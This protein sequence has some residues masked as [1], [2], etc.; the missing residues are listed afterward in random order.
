ML[1]SGEGGPCLPEILQCLRIHIG[2]LSL[3]CSVVL[4]PG[5]Q[6]SSE[7]VLCVLRHLWG[8]ESH[9]EQSEGPGG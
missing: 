9:W 2:E 6:R 7:V 1:R 5:W 4:G 3:V 8:S